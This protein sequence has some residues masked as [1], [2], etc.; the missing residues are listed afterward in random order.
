MSNILTMTYPE[1]SSMEV[2]S[3]FISLCSLGFSIAFAIEKNCI[4]LFERK[5]KHNS[6]E[7]L[8]LL[9]HIYSLFPTMRSTFSCIS[10]T[11]IDISNV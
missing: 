6:L 7:L 11:N 5:L 2:A 10:E 1:I 4:E 3:I 9:I 8:Y